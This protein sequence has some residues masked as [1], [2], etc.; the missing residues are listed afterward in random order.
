MAGEG[1]VSEFDIDDSLAIKPLHLPPSGWI[2]HIPFASWLVAKLQPKV[3]VELGTHNGASYLAFCQSVVAGGLSTRGFAV[4]TW[5]GDEHAGS[6]GDEVLQALR[7]AHDERYGGF[8]NL[9]RM[10]F[11]EALPRFPDGSIE[12]LHIDG[13]HT[14]DAV[15]HDFETWLPKVSAR[16]GV[17]LFHDTNE[18][19]RDFGVWKLWDEIR[20]THPS[21]E[22]LHAHGLGVLLVGDELPEA[23]RAIAS[24]SAPG[25]VAPVLF[26]RLG[27][28]IEDA[29]DLAGVREENRGLLQVRDRYIDLVG[30]HEASIDWAKGLESELAQARQHLTSSRDE[31]ERT[32]AWA[33]SLDGDLERTRGQVMEAQAEHDKT[34][35]WAKSIDAD[36]AAARGE[37]QRLQEEHA[38]AVAW[39][40]SLGSELDEVRARNAEELQAQVEHARALERHATELRAQLQSILASRAWR[41]SAPLRRVLAWGR[42][43]AS[44]P[45]IPPAPVA[46]VR[47]VAAPRDDL[48][49]DAVDQPLVSIIIPTYGKYAYTRACL[50]SLRAHGAQLPF[51]VLVAED[52]SGDPE[53]A[54]LRNVPGLHYHEN[55]RNL[56]FLRSCNAAAARARGEFLC[57]L[58]NDTEVSD[59][60]L[61]QLVQVFRDRGDAGLVGSKLVY[62]DGRLQEAGGIIWR[63]GSGWNHGRLQDPDAPEY[64]YLREADY[65]SGASLLVRA[66][67]FAALG[68][69]DERYAPAYYEDTDLAF[70]VREAGLKVYYCPRSVVVHHEGISHGTDTSSGGKA[71]MLVNQGKFVERW[72]DRLQS[73]HYPNGQDVFRAR[74]RAFGR[75]LVLVVDH[76]VPQRDRD[77]GSRAMLQTIEQLVGMGYVVKFW[78]Q[79]H[80]YDPA[81]RGDLEDL[82][83]EIVAGHHRVGAF[84]GFMRE[85]GMEFDYVM[86]SRPT[87]AVDFIEDTKRYSRAKI[88][89]YGI[90]L[91]YRRMLAQAGVDGSG[92][93]AAEEMRALERRMWLASDAIIYPSEEEAEVV[94]AETGL[95]NIH[96]VPL[97][98]FGEDDLQPP[99]HPPTP[100]RILF[101][102]G[103]AHPPNVDAALWL[104]REIFPRI[105]AAIPEVTLDLV[106]SNPADSVRALA[107]GAIGVHANVSH[108]QLARHYSDAS[109]AIVPLRYGGGVKLKVVEAMS[110]GVPVV[111]TPVGAQ[112][113]PG[114][115]QA[116]AVVDGAQALADAVVQRIRDPDAAAQ[117][118]A[119]A[120]AYLRAHYSAAQMAAALSRVFPDPATACVAAG[121]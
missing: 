33:K 67:L 88:V 23:V 14:Y 101:V 72:K 58:N 21:F 52:A 74:D 15:R 105:Q 75:K 114:L 92:V 35:A 42:G 78:P 13:L 17:I 70:R 51:E 36:L 100:P 16:R 119:T 109:V 104:A 59:G 82:G 87:V 73:E 63:D 81:Y 117:A 85:H 106:G 61:D 11:D 89:F 5:Q 86:L 24:W 68:G 53:I 121:T 83:V 30:E 112:G 94:R 45:E 103:F 115:E 50:E 49:F 77:A 40:Q 98:Y 19:E 96:A 60:W 9:L 79:N 34:V 71:H 90:D 108:E 41:V 8:S 44:A 37:I 26:E 102:A 76:Y 4:D 20:A 27:K 84:S 10:T 110:R 107:G 32:V 93:A 46:R 54:Q 69:F 80:H 22:F 3:L 62:P 1:G 56:G 7:A 97:Y 99:R 43:T 57:F 116:V 120:L 6:Y 55:V 113:L 29:R 28:A 95:D 39:A 38:R 64:N 118:A 111:T 2:G 25:A 66:G 47:N 91:H 31:H 18:R 12:L 48:R 65:C